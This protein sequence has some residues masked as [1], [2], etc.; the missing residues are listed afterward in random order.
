MT[1]TKQ[2]VRDAKQL[3][4]FCLLDGRVDEDRVRL[5]VQKVLEVKRRGY[6]TV[7][8]HFLRLLKLEYERHA[9]KI[10]SAV[11][12]PTDLQARIQMGLR[13]LR[14]GLSAVHPNP[15]LIGA[16]ASRSA[17]TSMTRK[18][19]LATLAALWYHERTGAVRVTGI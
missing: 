5:A 12:L 6:L 3:F 16:R 11:P 10:E 15:A 19:G 14:S 7:L 9:A 13:Y 2:A 1:T 18:F 4:R 17:A 8:R